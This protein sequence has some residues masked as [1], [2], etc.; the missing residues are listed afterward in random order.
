MPEKPK[1]NSEFVG[2]RLEIAR[3]LRRMTL[4]E[5]ADGVASSFGLISHYENG[6]KQPSPEVVAALAE[7][8]GVNPTFFYEPLTDIWRDDE[9]SFRHRRT[10]PEKVKRQARAH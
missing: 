4:N 5:V 3:T 10:T 1:P 9:C 7:L 2:E 8:L 6:R